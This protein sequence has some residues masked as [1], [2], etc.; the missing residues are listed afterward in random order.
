MANDSALQERLEALSASD[1]R[2]NIEK[3]SMR[4]LANDLGIELSRSPNPLYRIRIDE[5]GQQGFEAVAFTLILNASNRPATRAEALGQA[6]AQSDGALFDRNPLLLVFDYNQSRFLVVAA[7]TLFGAFA[8]EAAKRE[9]PASGSS[10]FSLTPNFEHRTITMYANVSGNDVWAGDLPPLDGDALIVG[11][12][13]VRSATEAA[14]VASI[15]EAVKKRLAATPTVAVGD[16]NPAVLTVPLD[17]FSGDDIRIDS[18]SWRMIL[19]AIRSSPAVILVGPPG[20]GK[21]AL[22]SKAV[23]T[24]SGDPQFVPEGGVFHDPLWATPDESWTARDLVGGDTIVDG[25]IRFRPGWVVRAIADDRWLILDEANRADMDRIFGGLLTWLSGGTVA[26]GSEH[27]GNGARE[28]L[29]GWTA[30]ASSVSEGEEQRAIR[31]KAGANWRLL[32]T[33]NALDAQRVFRFGQA[34]GRRFVRVPVPAL[35]PD[36]FVEVLGER[37]SRLS[38]DLRQAVARLYAAHHA[39]PATVLGPALFLAMCGYLA[40]AIALRDESANIADNT[41]SEELL[42][43]AYVVHIGTWLAQ[44]EPSDRDGLRD[45]AQQSG[46]FSD[47]EWSW[48]ETMIESLA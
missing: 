41:L 45:R 26:I 27:S 22:L 6:I 7:A 16:P 48:I 5:P 28:I 31:Y 35:T 18:R 13:A 24:L 19:T 15:V 2:I 32:G 30:G 42:A 39:S 46:V 40:S 8:K 33:Y 17:E 10:S 21:T 23:R 29:L 34:L 1:P 12:K 37:A 14:P 38:A 25:Q 47:A 36:L 4:D 43:E 9:I 20:T 3:I 11:L 44:L